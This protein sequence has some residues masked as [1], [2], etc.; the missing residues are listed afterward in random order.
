MLS[1]KGS[2]ISWIDLGEVEMTMG[3][4]GGG[5]DN[6]DGGMNGWLDGWRF[7]IAVDELGIA[8]E[9]QWMKLLAQ[10]Y[11]PTAACSWLGIGCVEKC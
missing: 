7:E 1:R 6:L 2:L 11:R 10:C 5:R 3:H 9:I 8:V 4:I